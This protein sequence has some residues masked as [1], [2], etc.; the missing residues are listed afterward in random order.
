MKKTATKRKHPIESG[1]SEDN[2]SEAQIAAE[3]NDKTRIIFKPISIWNLKTTGSF[4]KAI[5]E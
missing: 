2:V 4:L 3:I 1:V 5:F